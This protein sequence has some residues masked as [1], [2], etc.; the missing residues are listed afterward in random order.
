MS[1]RRKS[2]RTRSDD[3]YVTVGHS[4]RP[5]LFRLGAVHVGCFWGGR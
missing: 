5:P 4:G 2:I 1:G 3:R